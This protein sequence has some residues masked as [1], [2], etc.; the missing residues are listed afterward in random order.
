LDLAP[1]L[2]AALRYLRVDWGAP[3]PD[4]AL[5]TLAGARPGAGTREEFEREVE[6]HA[7]RS[8]WTDLLTFWARW[9]RSI[10]SAPPWLCLPAFARHL[11][12]A[13]QLDHVGMLPAQ[14]V[15][16]AQRRVGRQ[17]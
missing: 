7:R 8:S 12:Y 9:R 3:V 2:D 5:R 14:L 16:S 15:R 1:Y 17:G 13:F 4:E 10:G 11:Q 6:P